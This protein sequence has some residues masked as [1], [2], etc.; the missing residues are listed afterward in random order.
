M[1]VACYLYSACPFVTAG[2][3]TAGGAGVLAAVCQL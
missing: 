2:S 3:G 1:R